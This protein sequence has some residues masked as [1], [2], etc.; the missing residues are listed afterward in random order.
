MTGSIFQPCKGLFRYCASILFIIQIIPRRRNWGSHSGG[1]EISISWDINHEGWWKSTTWLSPDYMVCI[2]GD[3]T[4]QF[5]E[6][7]VINKFHKCE[8]K[9]KLA[10]GLSQLVIPQKFWLEYFQINRSLENMWHVE[11]FLL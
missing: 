2:H 3:K 7:F 9:F 11:E 4:L 6:E 8:T 10:I 1:Y 5:Q